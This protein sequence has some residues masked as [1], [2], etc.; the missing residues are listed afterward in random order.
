[1]AATPQIADR[2]ATRRAFTLTELMVVT[3][4]IGVMAA[5]SVPSFQ[6]AMTQSRADIA[7]ANLRA[8]WAAERLY[9]L[10]NH[11]Y[12][13]K[14]SQQSPLPSG[15]MQLGLLDPSLPLNASGA[16]YQNGGYY[17][18]VT[19]GSDPTSTFTATATN[20]F[21]GPPNTIMIDQAGTVT[22]TPPNTSL[23]F[24]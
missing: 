17:F 5:M 12:T 13:D 16:T 15:L 14:L 6:R 3:T 1:M 18:S 24:Q 23:T 22:T 8:I 4:L 10:E 9:W 2:P 11:A 21:A 20:M 7:A 19:P